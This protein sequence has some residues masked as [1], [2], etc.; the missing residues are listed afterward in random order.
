MWKGLTGLHRVSLHS[1][2]EWRL[3]A[4]S[5]HPTSVSDH[6]N[7]LLEE[8]LQIPMNTFLN[9]VEDLPRKLEAVIAAK[10]GP[11]SY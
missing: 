11:T 6:N 3:R 8:W 4:R 10:G 5:S 1:E 7:G 2:L 9:L